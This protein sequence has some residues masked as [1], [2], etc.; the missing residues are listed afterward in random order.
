[1]MAENEVHAKPTRGHLYLSFILNIQLLS[2]WQGLL[3]SDIQNMN[4]KL[5]TRTWLFCRPGKKFSK[6]PHNTSHCTGLA[7]V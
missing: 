6:V 4:C 3:F 7:T 5:N 2:G 1:M